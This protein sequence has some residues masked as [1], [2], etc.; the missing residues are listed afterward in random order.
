MEFS[1]KLAGYGS[2]MTPFSILK[3]I[4]LKWFILPSKHF[5]ANLFFLHYDLSPPPLLTHPLGHPGGDTKKGE[6][7]L[8]KVKKVDFKIHYRGFKEFLD[9]NNN[10]FNKTSFKD[11]GLTSS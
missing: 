2:S 7:G 10:N 6:G 11:W 9:N 5:K 4:V 8:I 1:I 3:K